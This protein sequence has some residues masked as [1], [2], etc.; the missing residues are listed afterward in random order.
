[1]IF[2]EQMKSMSMLDVLFHCAVSYVNQVRSSELSKLKVKY[3]FL[4]NM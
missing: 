1:M 2:R 3:I 4:V